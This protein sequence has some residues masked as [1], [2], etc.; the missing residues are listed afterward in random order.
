MGVGNP[1][2]ETYCYPNNAMLQTGNGLSTILWCGTHVTPTGCVINRLITLLAAKLLQNARA[3]CFPVDMSPF[4]HTADGQD[5]A[6]SHSQTRQLSHAELQALRQIVREQ[7]IHRR[8]G[9]FPEGA[10]GD[11]VYFC[12]IRIGGRFPPAKRSGG[13][14][15]DW[16]RAKSLGKWPSSSIVRVPPRPRRR[17][18]PEVYFLP[19]VKCCHSSSDHRS[20]NT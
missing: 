4:S 20:S 10:P 12:E 2:E 15:P 13:F 17:K 3:R 19:R 1:A 16:D 5:H 6:G 7:K 18:I 14:F 11:G 9:D 8:T